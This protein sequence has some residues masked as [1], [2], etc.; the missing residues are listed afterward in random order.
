L[1]SMKNPAMT[2]VNLAALKAG[3]E[4]SRLEKAASKLQAGK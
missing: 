1:F 2:A 4:Q 3:M